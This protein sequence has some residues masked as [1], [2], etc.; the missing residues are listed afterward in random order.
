MSKKNFTD[1]VNWAQMRKAA[2]LTL[3]QVA[4]KSGYGVATI[5][6]L[7]KRGEGSARLKA[8]LATLYGTHPDYA[9]NPAVYQDPFV[10][11]RAAA[12][13]LDGSVQEKAAKF[14]EVLREESKRIA[15]RQ[16]GW[17]AAQAITEQNVDWKERALAAEAKLEEA[18]RTL[19]EILAVNPT[20]KTS[21]KKKD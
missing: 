15:T 18:R 2:G 21:R 17:E 12:D 4:E 10:V 5:N 8:L 7:E 20:S 9:L 1:S 6:G 16:E 14:N 13:A 3:Q 11:A 19:N